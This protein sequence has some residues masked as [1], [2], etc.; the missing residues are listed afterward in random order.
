MYLSAGSPTIFVRLRGQ[1]DHQALGASADRAREMERRG[2]R[3]SARQ[4]E[5]AERLQ[6]RV[7]LVDL[8]FEPRHLR[9]HDPQ[10]LPFGL[11]A[12][13]GRAEIGAEVEQVVLDAAQH[14]V[15]LRVLFA[16]SMRAMPSAEFVSS[17]VP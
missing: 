3:R 14:G 10:R 4:H 8:A 1:F 2:R 13:V 11:L 5:G 12:S 9:V 16:V 7:E 15:E 17:T 6:R